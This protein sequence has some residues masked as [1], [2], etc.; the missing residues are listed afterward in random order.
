MVFELS[1]APHSGHENLK[2]RMRCLKG[3]ARAN[4]SKRAG[5]ANQWGHFKV[6][7]MV[8]KICHTIAITAIIK[9][10]IL[11]FWLLGR[12]FLWNKLRAKMTINT[13]RYFSAIVSSIMML[14]VAFG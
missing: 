14:T 5:I 10:A 6:K 3:I 2:R 8:I 13:Q 9:V 1:L 11:F 4:V 7:I 12:C